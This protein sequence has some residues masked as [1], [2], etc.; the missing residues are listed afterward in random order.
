MLSTRR[1]PKILAP[2]FRHHPAAGLTSRRSS[3][4]L[5]RMH[6]VRQ[7]IV[8]LL[9]VLIIGVV[10][11]LTPKFRNMSAEY[12]TAEAIH[13]LSAFVVGN[14]G[15]WPSSPADL[16]DKYPV[17]GE[18]D[19]DYGMTSSRL[20]ADP[21]LLKQSVRPESGKFLTYPHYEVKLA[22]LLAEIRES[23]STPAGEAQAE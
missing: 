23:A 9:I 22:G 15:R 2:Y 3:A 20:I 13:D 10:V 18:V 12:A 19:I 17:G 1:G 6:R 8:A 16:A 5:L 11:I 7:V 4:P 14:D 21:A